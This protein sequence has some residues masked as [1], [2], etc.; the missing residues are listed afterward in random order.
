M[1]STNLLIIISETPQYANQ[2]NTF[3]PV[4][5]QDVVYYREPQIRSIYDQTPRPQTYHIEQKHVDHYS[6]R[7]SATH[8]TI[9]GNSIPL[10]A[11]QPPSKSGSITSGYPVRSQTQYQQAPAPASALYTASSRPLY[12]SPGTPMS[13]PQRD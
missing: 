1:L 2:P 3:Y 11:A 8:V 5:P 6:L 4:P 13:Y 9:H 10:T 7:P 12:Q